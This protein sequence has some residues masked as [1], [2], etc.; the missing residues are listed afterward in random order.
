MKDW[1]GQGSC[2]DPGCSALQRSG[3]RGACSLSCICEG[4]SP[5]SIEQTVAYSNYRNPPPRPSV[6][7][8]TR[9]QLWS[10]NIKWKFPEINNS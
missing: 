3:G 10:E 5:F 8:F 4:G 9:G 2:T 7:P 6:T 1:G